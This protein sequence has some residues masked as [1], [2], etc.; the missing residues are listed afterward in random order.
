MELRPSEIVDL[1]RWVDAEVNNG[2][3]HQFFNNSSGD[4]TVETIVA[5]TQIG[6]TKTAGIVRSAA[7]MF[8]G[9]MPPRD[10]KERIEILWREFPDPRSFYSLNEEFYEY[11]DGLLETLITNFAAKSGAAPDPYWN[12]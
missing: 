9:G 11:P 12:V 8:P 3:F 2:G 6:A 5:L 10:R 7:A 1:V 4:K